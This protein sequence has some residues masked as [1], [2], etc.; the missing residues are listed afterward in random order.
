MSQFR[1]RPLA[2]AVSAALTGSVIATT[3]AVPAYADTVLE[4]IVVTAQKRQENLQDVPV[5]VQ[6]LGNKDL[7]ELNL[8]SFEDYIQFLPT[9][10]FTYSGPGYG[11]VY[12]RGIVSGGSVHSGSMPSVGVYLDEQPITT[13]SQILDV[14]IYDIAR[15]ETLAGPQG[16]LF[17]QGSQAGTLRIITNK[18]DSKGFE[19]GYDVNVNSVDGGDMGYG[20]EGFAN[21]PLSEKMALRVVGWSQ[22]DG[23]YIDSV[24]G[25]ITY[26]A[27]GIERCNTDV[28]L[29]PNPKVEDNFNDATSTGA[30]ALLKVD[31]NDNWTV[32]PG[33]MYQ[34]TETNGNWSYMPALGDLKIQRYFEDSTDEDWYQASLTVEG[35]IGDMDLVYAGAYLDR[36]LDSLYDYSGYSEYLENLY[37]YYGYDCYVYDATGACAD[38]SQYVAGKE[39]FTRASNEI[40]LQSNQEKRLRWVVGYF[41]QQQKHDFDLQWKIP[42]M[43]PA[44]SVIPNGDTTWQT[45]QIRKDR[46]DAFFGEITYD[47]TEKLSVT[48]GLRYFEYENSLYGF[49]GFL[50]HCTGYYDADGNFVEDAAGDPQFPCFDTRILDDV[51]KGDDLAHKINV[52]YTVNDDLMVYATYSQGFRAGGVNRARVP[53]VPKYEPDWVYNYEAG[54]KSTWMGGRL[55]FNGAVYLEDWDNVQLSFLD[56]TVSNLTIIRNVGKAQTI[57]TEF[58]LAFQ[59]TDDLTLSFAGSYNN[60]ELSEAFYRDS[61]DQAAGLDPRAPKGTPM[62]WVPKFQ[63]TAIGRYNFDMGSFP[64][65]AQLA[66][67]YTGSRWNDLDTTN[68]RRA[69]MDAYTI[70]NG[71]VGI[72][73]DSWTVEL[74]GSN[75]TDERA[76]NQIVDAGYPDSTLDTRT[77]TNRPRT[78]GIRFSQRF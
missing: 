52:N 21:I 24:P 19:A 27:S 9:V 56:F 35:H 63:A 64:S 10:S 29:G 34:T 20:V 14:H 55:R 62:P 31:L 46:D 72:E 42:A 48:Y 74:F 11:E 2:R 67:A 39:N 13:I 49:N 30:R 22:H 41:T 32:T 17:G 4:E 75:L 44:A 40:R 33:I 6:V 28:N 57:G 78:F 36:N 23:G 50:R 68:P 15:I 70:V 60:A 69:E 43:D 73:K 45:Y 26:A 16:T 5:S 3:I 12:M 71:A 25:C 77:Y 47:F 8:K 1:K 51:A 38:P 37:A 59:A 18:P 65:Y 76:Q 53:G 7:Q 58:D 66:M 61:D 54:W